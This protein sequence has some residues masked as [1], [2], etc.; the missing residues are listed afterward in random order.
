MLPTDA[1]ER[2]NYPI[3][4]G[5]VDYFP[6]ALAAVAQVSKV[7]NDQH[8]PGQSLHWNRSKST[9]EADA[10]M[11][12]FVERGKVDVDGCRHSAKM[13]WRALA[14]LQK[15]IEAEQAQISLEPGTVVSVPPG[16]KL[17][18][19][20]LP[21]WDA[22]GPGSELDSR[23]GSRLVGAQLRCTNRGHECDS[24]KTCDRA[25]HCC[26]GRSIR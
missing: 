17:H 1:K 18:G 21:D 3:G 23:V 22:K 7:G 2:K 14:F 4:T 16:F 5:V 26:E 13:V 25:N 11:R 12:H 10:L 15:E 20:L 19:T 9:D 6:D 24:P 8:N